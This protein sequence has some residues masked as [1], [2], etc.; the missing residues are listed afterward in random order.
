MAESLSDQVI[1][2]IEQ[3]SGLYHRLVLVVALSGSGKTSVLQDVA[4]RTGFPLLNLNLELSHRLLSLTERERALQAPRPLEEIL[5][6][7]DR[8]VVL[9]DN[10]EILFEVSLKQDL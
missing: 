7:A 10:V 8:D 3:A 9:L 2:K 4:Q 5:A 6:Q 1:R